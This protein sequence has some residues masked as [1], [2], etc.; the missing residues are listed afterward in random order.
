MAVRL[1]VA[2][3]LLERATGIT[4][5]ASLATHIGLTTHDAAVGAAVA[6]ELGQ[7]GRAARLRRWCWTITQ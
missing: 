6:V 5:G 4:N 1:Q 3:F 2:H 7:A